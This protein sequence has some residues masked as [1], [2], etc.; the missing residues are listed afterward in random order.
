MKSLIRIVALI[1]FVYAVFFALTTLQS[2]FDRG[3]LKRASAL[4]FGSPL[5]GG[6]MTVV[7]L[8]AAQTG[9][10]PGEISCLMN[11]ESRERGTV[12]FV[13]EEKFEWMV[14][15]VGSRIEPH[16]PSAQELLQKWSEPKI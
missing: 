4:F 5:P 9:K 1:F 3:D 15:V 8:I 13:C 7:D 12:L 2:L 6:Q 11:L 16:S 14:D 10:N